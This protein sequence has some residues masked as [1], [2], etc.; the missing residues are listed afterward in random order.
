MSMQYRL[1]TRLSQEELTMTEKYHVIA[2]KK[3]GS[4]YKGIMTTKEP[5]VTN[6]IIGS[7][8]IEY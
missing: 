2:T 5:Y 8:K 4:T 6:R 1:T 7:A 3:D